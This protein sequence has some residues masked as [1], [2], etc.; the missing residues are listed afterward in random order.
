M[1]YLFFCTSECDDAL[2]DRDFF[3]VKD[4]EFEDT[5]RNALQ[6]YFNESYPENPD[7]A[8]NY[9]VF[10]TGENLQDANANITHFC[11]RLTVVA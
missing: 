1:D 5:A 3:L 11:Y 6:C 10:I 2:R 9:S 7:L 4:A 8:E